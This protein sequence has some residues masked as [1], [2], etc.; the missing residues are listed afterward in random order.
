MTYVGSL[1]QI[2]STAYK[3]N[4]VAKGYRSPCRDPLNYI[5]DDKYPEEY[6]MQTVRLYAHFMDHPTEQ[7]NFSREKGEKFFWNLVNNGNER[8]RGN[9]K[10]NLPEGNDTPVLDPLIQWRIAEVATANG[11]KSAYG[12]H[13]DEEHYW[14]LS[15]GKSRN[16]YSKEVIKKYAVHPD[17]LLNV[18]FIST[19]PDSIASPTY[20]GVIAGIALGTS[21][22]ITGAYELGKPWWEF[23]TTLNHEIG[24]VFGL[25]HAWYRNDGCDDTP[26]H[27]NCYAPTGVPPC[28]GPVSNNLMDYNNSQMAITPCQIG[29]MHRS[30]ANIKGKQRGLVDP[31]WCELDNT[32]IITIDEDRNWAGHKD[33][34][35]SVVVKSGHTLTIHCRTSMPAGSKITVEPGAKLILE[36]AWLHNSCGDE[37]LGIELQENKKLK[38]ELELIGKCKIENVRL[39]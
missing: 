22:K 10:M 38:G 2:D 32:K 5:P 26:A 11:N 29:K 13:K 28:E 1:D 25:G 18:F 23:S 8:L 27:K 37:W 9:H 36:N 4:A 30:I 19:H 31:I 35:H 39:D 16:N 12:F 6:Y 3:I 15:K 17:S 24:H 20:K 33:L 21:I 7:Y 34:R 14:Y